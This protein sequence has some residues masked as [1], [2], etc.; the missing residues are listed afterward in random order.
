MNECKY[1]YSD[2][3]YWHADP[4][5]QFFCTGNDGTDG[6]GHKLIASGTINRVPVLL[7]SVIL[8]IAGLGYVGFNYYLYINPP[9]S[10]G[11]TFIEKT[12]HIEEN[13]TVVS[14]SVIRNPDSQPAKINYFTKDRTAVAGQDYIAEEGVLDFT[15]DVFEKTIK[16]T[17][18]PDKLYSEGTEDFVIV[19]SNTLN[20]EQHI[21]FINEPQQ[22]SEVIT[23]AQT[24]VR[25]LST[26]AMDV[27]AYKKR[28]EVISELLQEGVI[29]DRALFL[30]YQRTQEQNE[31]NL[32]RSRERYME[33]FRDLKS[34]P[35]AAVQIAFDQWLA[36]L[37]RREYT[38]QHDATSLAEKQFQQFL[39]NN[40]MEMDLWSSEL[41]KVI[42]DIDLLFEDESGHSI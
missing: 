40:I 21:I 34:L 30:E 36:S 33:I 25:N 39:S 19:L 2:H 28:I 3:I 10:N 5:G 38:Q 12:T 37:T 17:I 23:S 18:L 29:Q 31:T 15:L 1:A 6:C 24:L 20:K 41:E 26:V 7:A 35:F 16:I 8:L 11:Y 27:A 13:S 32:R 22:N 9:P 42:P 4:E 14:I